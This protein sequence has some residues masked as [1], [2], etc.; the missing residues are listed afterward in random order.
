MIDST[1]YARYM[2]AIADRTKSPIA[3]ATI[4]LYYVT[5]SDAMSTEQFEMAARRVFSEYDDFG[6]PPP[7]VFLTALAAT[8]PPIDGDAILRRISALGSHHPN[9]GWIYPR[10]DVIRDA[11]GDG[12][13]QAYAAAGADRCFADDGSVTQDIARRTFATE[14]TATQRRAPGLPLLPAPIAPRRLAS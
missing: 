5:L 7:A 3:P 4:A 10:L 14:L 2:A 13:A 11:L 9:R 1:I 6:F 8:A 12:I